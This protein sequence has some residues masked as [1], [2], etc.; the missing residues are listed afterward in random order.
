MSVMADLIDFTEATFA[1]QVHEQ[2]AAVQDI[3][4]PET[5]VLLVP[6]PLQTPES[7]ADTGFAFTHLNKHWFCLA[8]MNDEYHCL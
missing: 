3:M 6:H 2:V 8:Q 5:A 7:K 4:R 1:Q